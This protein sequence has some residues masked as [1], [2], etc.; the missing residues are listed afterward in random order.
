MLY[1][2][3]GIGLAVAAVIVVLLALRFIVR[4]DW[5]VAWLKGSVALAAALLGVGLAFAAADLYSYHA[6]TQ[7]TNI[8]TVSIK[9]IG[10][11]LYAVEVAAP[12]EEA[13]TFELKGDLWQLDARV[14]TWRG[15][16]AVLKPG[17]RLDR[18]SGRYLSLEQERHAERSVHEVQSGMGG[19]DVW[20]W[21][22]DQEWVPWV[23]ADYG[24][25]T[26]MPMKDG[27]QY[28]ISLSQKGMLARPLNSVAVDAV[29]RWN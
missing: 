8:A 7:E 25:A 10:K 18:L 28:V 21:L 29:E 4:R 17:Y 19:F 2:T 22:H 1:Q 5:F 16:L 12:D 20:R 11:Q 15:P 9:A 24:A 23:D 6:V 3:L 26:Y 14:I 13:H 27:A